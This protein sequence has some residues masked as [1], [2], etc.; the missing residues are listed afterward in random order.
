MFEEWEEEHF[1]YVLLFV[2]LVSLVYM[3]ATR[4]AMKHKLHPHEI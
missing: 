2:S 4:E 3:V 1:V